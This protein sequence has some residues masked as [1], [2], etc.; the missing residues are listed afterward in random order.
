MSR[1]LALFLM[2]AIGIGGVSLAEA[3]GAD[4]PVKLL[5]AVFGGDN[6]KSE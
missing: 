4:W 6:P 2:A 1:D 5:R 3:F